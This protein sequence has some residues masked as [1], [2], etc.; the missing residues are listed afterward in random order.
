MTCK[1]W[2]Q[3]NQSGR[4][5]KTLITLILITDYFAAIYA[6]RHQ[7]HDCCFTDHCLVLTDY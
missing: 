6:E 7:V 5:P 3:S 2:R 4:V 1:R